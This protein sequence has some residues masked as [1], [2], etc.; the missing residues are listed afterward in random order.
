M[1][2][3][4]AGATVLALVGMAAT[5]RA[6]DISQPNPGAGSIQ[7]RV[8]LQDSPDQP[9]EQIPVHLR[10]GSGIPIGVVYTSG[11]GQFLFSNLPSGRYEVSVSLPGF[12]KFSQTVEIHRGTGRIQMQAYLLKREAPR[13]EAGHPAV[14]VEEMQAPAGARREYEKGVERLRK[15]ESA[16]AERHFKKAVALYPT[17]AQAW[18]ELG[19]LYARTGRPD[20]ALQSFREALRHNEKNREALLCLARLLND[21]SRHL[22]ALR[23]AAQF[24]QLDSGDARNHL[25]IARGL[26]G[27]GKVEEA[28][29]AASQLERE[30]HPQTPEVHLVLFSIFRTR[31]NALAAAGEL[32]TYLKETEQRGVAPRDPAVARARRLLTQLETEI[33]APK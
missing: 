27:M 5:V 17:Y 10:Q 18:L 9:L 11:N 1:L 25:E 2:W 28:E 20:D 21:Q 33:A 31:R 15:E 22:E 23:A 30:P 12:Q 7:G 29:L 6:Q 32:R 19:R 14:S 26:L 13:S 8:I 4:R 16:A 24:E 3:L